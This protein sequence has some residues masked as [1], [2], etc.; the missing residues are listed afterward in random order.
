MQ[1]SAS[2]AHFLTLALPAARS[3]LLAL[4]P[5]QLAPPFVS[6]ALAATTALMAPP[7]GLVLT[8]DVAT[9]ALTALAPQLHVLTKCL[10]VADGALCKSKALPSSWKQ[11]TASTTASGTSR[12]VTA[13]SANARPFNKVYLVFFRLHPPHAQSTSRAL[14]AYFPLAHHGGCALNPAAVH[15]VTG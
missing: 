8:A 6:D 3:V 2:K 10:Q 1:R 7:P 13:S 4:S 5:L 11:P 14:A 15:A 9:T 12:Q